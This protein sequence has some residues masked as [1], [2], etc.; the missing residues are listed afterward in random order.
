MIVLISV[1]YRLGNFNPL[2]TME[3]VLIKCRPKGAELH[4][5]LKISWKHFR[6]RSREIMSWLS[7]RLKN[8]A[9]AR[10]HIHLK[11]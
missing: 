2:R 6:K 7:S 4:G 10:I 8:K 1:Y 3:L 11:G 9:E 5:S